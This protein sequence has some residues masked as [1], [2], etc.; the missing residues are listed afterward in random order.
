VVAVRARGAD[1]PRLMAW[2]R[3]HE[4]EA[5]T[6]SELRRHLRQSLPEYMIPSMIV[7]VDE[8]PLTPNGKIDRRAL[9]D[10]FQRVE[11][12]T[13][14]GLPPSTATERIIADT[15]MRLLNVD[16]L[17]VSDRF[18]EIGGHSLLAMRAA[19]EITARTGRTIEPRLLFF[20]TLGQV[21]EVCDGQPAPGAMHLA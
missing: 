18:F 3:F 19:N 7:P 5:A 14:D 6:A 20:L 21:A 1:D 4:D 8:I 10:A 11:S 17:V 2:V 16:R 12:D 9:P 15:W 13:E